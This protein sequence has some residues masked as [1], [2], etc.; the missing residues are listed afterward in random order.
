[1]NRAT[2]K[3]MFSSGSSEWCTPKPFFK[4]LDAEFH[5]TTDVGA[6]KENALCQDYLGLDNGRPALTSDWGTVNFC[7]PPYGRGIGS[8]VSKAFLES[9]KGKIVVMLIPVRTDTKWFHTWILGK[10]SEIR[11]IRGR[12]K[13]SIP[14]A[15]NKENI[16]K[17]SAPFPSM[18]VVFEPFNHEPRFTAI[19]AESK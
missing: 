3:V 9:R 6:T 1:M 7:N 4:K 11:F 18:V 8:W 15:K 5:F 17:Y 13:F 14:Q 12:L 16:G 10:A 19:E 2:Q